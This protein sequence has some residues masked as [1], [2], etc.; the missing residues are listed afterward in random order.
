MANVLLP[1]R[2]GE[3]IRPVLLG[4]RASVPISAAFA[5]VVLERLL[6]LLLLFC[7]L[8][9]LG[10]VVPVP[11]A[12]RRASYLILAALTAAVTI[13]MIVLWHRER[14]VASARRAFG[15]LPRNA[16]SVL[17]DVLDNFLAGA[18][19]ISDARTILVVLAYSLAVWCVIAV[20]YACALIALDI[21]VP[22]AAASVSLTVVVAAFVS[23][24]QAPGY[25]GTWQA[26]C[27]AALGFYGVSREEAIGYSLVTHVVQVVVVVGLGAVCIVADKIGLRDLVAL[28]RSDRHERP[29]H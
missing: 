26:G 23:L 24:P 13:I 9:A 10:I 1:L 22:L 4:R 21:K 3:L 12:M 20:T 18:A 19:G 29:V 27:V 28:A 16:G 17:G 15:R 7:L 6:D 14:A 2:A 8:L 5:S 11:V 25:I